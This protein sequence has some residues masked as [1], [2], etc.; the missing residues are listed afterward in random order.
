MFASVTKSPQILQA[1]SNEDLFLTCV[2]CPSLVSIGVLS[3]IMPRLME[4]PLLGSL[5]I[6]VKK[7]DQK[8]LVSSPDDSTTD[9]MKGN[10]VIATELQEQG[11]VWCE[12]M[13]ERQTEVGSCKFHRPLSGIGLLYSEQWAAVEL[14]W[15]Q[16]SQEEETTSILIL[17]MMMLILIVTNYWYPPCTRHSLLSLQYLRY[18]LALSLFNKEETET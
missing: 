11:E 9:T 7:Q 10:Q 16:R 3:Q 18:L 15:A 2:T 5:Q 1:E 8:Y 13:L 12:L 17:Q 4:L 14:L 6:A